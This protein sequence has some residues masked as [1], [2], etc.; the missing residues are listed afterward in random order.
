MESSALQRRLTCIL[1]ADAVGYSKHMGQDEEGT[2]QVLAAHR[3]VIDGIIAFHRGRVVGTAGDSVLAEFNSAVEAVRCAVE[4]Q[5]ALRTRNDALPEHRRLQFRVG[6]NLGDVVVKDADLLGDGVNVAARLEALA[7]PGGICI[8]SSVYDQITGKLDLGFQDIGEQSLKN[9][10][11]P[12]R[13]YRVS[14]VRAAQALGMPPA[15]APVS[16][17]A[18]K[19]LLWAG[20]G[21]AVAVLAGLGVW[22][23]QGWFRPTATPAAAASHPAQAAPP[24]TATPTAPAL[25]TASIVPSSPAAVPASD[26]LL[27]PAAP[28]PGSVAVS[29]S[30]PAAARLAKPAASRPA[31]AAAKVAAVAPAAALSKPVQAPQAVDTAE[32]TSLRSAPPQPEPRPAP[33]ALARF[34]FDGTWSARVACQRHEEGA[35]GYK[36]DLIAQVHQGQLRAELGTAGEPG[37]LLLSGQIQ[38]D[39][40]AQLHAQGLTADP[41]YSLRGVRS[42]TPFQYDVDATFQGDQGQGRRLQGRACGLSFQRM[43]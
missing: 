12:V 43:P 26:A 11:R 7:E 8:A 22:W 3:A 23:S 29:A 34:P 18:S 16:A 40:S 35:L 27:A 5:D 42:G 28:V 25:T 1:A 41:K 2:I 31:P 13:V 20:M 30:A 19:P 17:S 37:W 6:V 4:I 33:P 9:I 10:P 38:T 15:A 14:G 36:V 24:V 39:G 32:P 21:A